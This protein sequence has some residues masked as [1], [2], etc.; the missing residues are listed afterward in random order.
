MAYYIF[1]F[2]G[3]RIVQVEIGNSFGVSLVRQTRSRGN[4]TYCKATTKELPL[5]SSGRFHRPDP[6][7]VKNA[8]MLSDEIERDTTGG[9][10]IMAKSD[11]TSRCKLYAAKAPVSSRPYGAVLTLCGV[12]T[13]LI[14]RKKSITHRRFPIGNTI[15]HCSGQTIFGKHGT[16]TFKGPS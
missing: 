8:A 6:T 10:G 12:R 7:Q 13:I 15:I 2:E 9:T 1:S 16:T 4:T 11:I 3:R 14:Q 5:N